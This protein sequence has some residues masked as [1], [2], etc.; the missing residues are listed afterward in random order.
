MSDPCQFRGTDPLHF[1]TF[2]C[3]FSA[4][5]DGYCKTHYGSGHHVRALQAKVTAAAKVLR[6]MEDGHANPRYCALLKNA[7]GVK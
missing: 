3:R 7:L 5:K 2:G 4:A 6:C 1:T